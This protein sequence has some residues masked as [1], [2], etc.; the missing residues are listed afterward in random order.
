MK[1]YFVLHNINKI[2]MNLKPINWALRARFERV[3]KNAKKNHQSVP[4]M[5]TVYLSIIN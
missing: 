2:D 4:I 1:E 3:V 5:P